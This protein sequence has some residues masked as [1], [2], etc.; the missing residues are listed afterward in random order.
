MSGVTQPAIERR[1]ATE[2]RVAGRRL[3]GFAATFHTEARIA[4]FVE[5]IRPGAFSTSLRSGR[6]VVALV[7]HDPT[8]LL[9]RTKTGTLKLEEDARGLKFTIDL[10]DTQSA[11]DVLALA[12]RGDIGGASFGFTVPKDGERWEGRRRELVRVELHEVSVVASWPA[13]P[14]TSVVARSRIPARLA[15]ARRYLETVR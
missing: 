6:D 11:R 3:E 15:R 7:D 9:A 13:Y 10:P 5:I 8:R 12:E 2:F 14:D 1:K 4:D